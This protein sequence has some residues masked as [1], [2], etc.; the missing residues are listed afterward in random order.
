MSLGLVNK[1]QQ[2]VHL[3]RVPKAVVHHLRDFRS[4]P[5]AQVQQVAIG[6]ELLDQL[7]GR[8][9]HGHARGFIDAAALHAHETVFD[10]VNPPDAVAPRDLVQLGHGFERAEPLAVHVHRHAGGKSNRDLL[11]FVGRLRGRNRHAEIDQ[12]DTVDREILQPARLITDVQAVLIRAIGLGHGRLD[13]NLLLF[14]IGDHFA[15]TGKQLAELFHPP[16]RDQFN[17]RLKRLGGELEAALIVAL[18]GRA[19]SIGGRAHF[20][21]YLQTNF[22]DQ[23]AGDRRAEQVDAFVLGLPLQNR[24]GEIAAQLFAGVHNPGA[25]GAVGAGFGQRGLAILARLTQIDIDRVD[26]VAL[27]LQ[28]AQ[29]D[30]SIQPA[31]VR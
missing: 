22:R 28:P 20:A 14:A 27:V 29:N 7:M 5:V 1:C 10:D 25:L 13:R 21:S 31:G 3:G 2:C 30:R 23:R 24:E 12:F 9:E 11:H 4:Q 6:R 16:R 19:M 26:F 8:I 18:A 15:A 17:G